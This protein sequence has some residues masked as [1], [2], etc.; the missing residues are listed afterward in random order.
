MFC[1]AGHISNGS[2]LWTDGQTKIDKGCFDRRLPILL[3]HLHIVL[4]LGTL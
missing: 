1:V 2:D 3:A 4:P